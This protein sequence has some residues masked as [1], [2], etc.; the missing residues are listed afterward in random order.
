MP[1]T[2]TPEQALR[3][4]LEGSSCRGTFE[5]HVTTEAAGPED[6]ERFRTVCRRLGVKCV[7][8]ELPNGAT[9]SQPM[10]ACHHHGE[11]GRVL[12][13][14]EVLCRGLRAAGFPLTRVKLEA[15]ATNEG[16]PETDE[17]AARCSADRY[18]EFHVKL[19]LGPDTD[20][21]ALRGCCA[22]HDARLSRNA[23]KVEL[24]GHS[25]RFVTLRRHGM[26]RQR[27]N[28]SLEA[29]E[30]DLVAAGFTVVNRQREY[31]LF[32]SALQLDAGWI[33]PPERPG[34]GS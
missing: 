4:C 30:R 23:L 10:T 13:E 29:L 19:L 26:G 25:E 31:S 7:L 27:A 8:I 14:V 22:R 9:R 32:D 28:A 11:I 17:E 16:I 6:Q 21:I 20:L 2:P 12:D 18:F 1:A 15:V 34:A 3:T 33:D 24:D 5:S